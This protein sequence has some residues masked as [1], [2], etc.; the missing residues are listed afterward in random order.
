M[1]H[2]RKWYGRPSIEGI[3][4]V[5]GISICVTVDDKVNATSRRRHSTPEKRHI[6]QSNSSNNIIISDMSRAIFLKGSGKLS[7]FPKLDFSDSRKSLV[8][9]PNREG[10]DPDQ[11]PHPH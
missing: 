10:G 5:F 4:G 7:N 3:L 9:F 8:N 11:N 6:K 2:M 1:R